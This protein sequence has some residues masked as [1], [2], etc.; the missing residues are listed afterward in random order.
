MDVISS[1]DTSYTLCSTFDDSTST[2]IVTATNT[3][4]DSLTFYDDLLI[5][6]TDFA[7]QLYFKIVVSKRSIL[8]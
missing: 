4:L 2:V 8:N 6:E 1:L 7:E 5:Y 3:G